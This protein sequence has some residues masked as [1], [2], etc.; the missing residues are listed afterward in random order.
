M[1]IKTLSP[2]KIDTFRRAMNRVRQVEIMDHIPEF[3]EY[4]DG[5]AHV[6]G[7]KYELV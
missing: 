4:I 6:K 1:V 7:E 3:I 5:Q 2:E